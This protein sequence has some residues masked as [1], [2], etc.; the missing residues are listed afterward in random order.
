[1]PGYAALT[2]QLTLVSPLSCLN[3]PP[4]AFSKPFHNK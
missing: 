2:L 4:E 1:M 3:K